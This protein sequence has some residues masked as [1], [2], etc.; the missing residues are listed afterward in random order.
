ME[1]GGRGGKGM[2]GRATAKEGEWRIGEGKVPPAINRRM[3]A[4]LCMI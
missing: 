2:E 3:K 4:I 1:R